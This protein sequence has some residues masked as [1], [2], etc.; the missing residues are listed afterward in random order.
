MD[1]KAE[2]TPVSAQNPADIASDPA[3]PR[4]ISR[5]DLLK[6]AAGGGAGLAV[7]SLI[8]LP[9]VRAATKNKNSQK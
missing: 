8:D 2:A 6:A 5:R 1:E 7:G 3:T 4:R 9:T